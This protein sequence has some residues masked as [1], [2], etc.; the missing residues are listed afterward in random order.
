VGLQPT[1]AISDI[2]TSLWA[3]PTIVT[4]GCQGGNLVGGDLYVWGSKSIECLS[5]L[6]LFLSSM[7]TPVHLTC[8]E[9]VGSCNIPG[10]YHK[11]CC[12]HYG[13]V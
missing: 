12:E 3:S 9:L 6:P 5:T 2:Y 11:E 1:C 10:L 13:A 8:D 4:G 7:T